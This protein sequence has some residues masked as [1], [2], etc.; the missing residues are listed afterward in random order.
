MTP[1]TKTNTDP[2]MISSCRHLF[3]RLYIITILLLIIIETAT[4]LPATSTTTTTKT[5]S[6]RQQKLAKLQQSQLSWRCYQKYCFWSDGSEKVF[7]SLKEAQSVCAAAD[8]ASWMLEIYDDSVN[9]DLSIFMSNSPGISNKDI[10]LNLKRVDT[11]WR[12]LDGTRYNGLLQ[13]DPAKIFF[14]K[15]MFY[16]FKPF[17]TLRNIPMRGACN[18]Q[19]NNNNPLIKSIQGP[20]KCYKLMNSADPVNWFQAYNLCYNMGGRLASLGD[21]TSQQL[22]ST[23]SGARRMANYWIGLT[24]SRWEWQR[25]PGS[26]TNFTN[27][28]N[29]YPYPSHLD[30]SPEVVQTI[31]DYRNGGIWMDNSEQKPV[32]IICMKDKA[33][34][35]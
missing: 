27:W 14:E 21:L 19:N 5:T 35:Q 1:T 24:N 7:G 32:A 12:W 30:R 2:S 26:I 34:P 6:S 20:N 9:T 10:L 25:K 3:F 29:G 17:A 4:P 15:I 11:E 31:Y 33:V 22:Q 16:I 13:Y 18:S 23:F 28:Y 8:P